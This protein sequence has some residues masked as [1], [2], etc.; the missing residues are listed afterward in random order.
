MQTMTEPKKANPTVIL[1]V[2]QRSSLRNFLE[3]YFADD[4]PLAWSSDQIKVINAIEA[5][6]RRGGL[7]AIGMPRG[8]GKTTIIERAVLYCAL[9]GNHPYLAIIGAT[10]ETA[11]ESLD[12]I[13][14]ILET[15]ELL[16]KV[17]ACELIVQNGKIV[18][19]TIKGECVIQAT[20]IH[21]LSGMKHKTKA[22][23][24][25][26]TFC[27]IDDPQSES[28]SRSP[29]RTEKLMTAMTGSILGVGGPGVKISAVAALTVI[30]RDDMADQ[31]LDRDL[32]PEWDGLRLKTLYGKAKNEDLIQAYW[33]RRAAEVSEVGSARTN[34]WYATNQ[35]RI[36]A[37]LRAA[38]PALRNHYENSAIQHA[39]NLIQDRGKDVFDAEYQNTPN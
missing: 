30:A 26:P 1:P 39:L 37:G 38:W 4:F 36:E 15:N 13:R 35:T 34:V 31:I 27:F 3:K 5:R 19:Q 23:I 7:K 10:N 21:S 2:I 28:S 18:L 11:K 25:R 24:V 8:T 20:G 22:G 32:Y 6:I 29:V 16:R 14:T 17:F 33:N 12:T 9:Y